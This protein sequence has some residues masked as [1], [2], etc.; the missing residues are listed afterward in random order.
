MEHLLIYMHH[1]IAVFANVEIKEN[2]AGRGAWE[3]GAGDWKC[4][5]DEMNRK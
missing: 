2:G 3:V 1:P 5:G 4:G